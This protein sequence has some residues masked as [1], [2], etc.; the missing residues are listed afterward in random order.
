MKRKTFPITFY[1]YNDVT[2]QTRLVKPRRPSNMYYD[3]CGFLWN[4]SGTRPGLE[5]SDSQTSVGLTMRREVWTSTRIA[6]LGPVQ[7]LGGTSG[8]LRGR[9]G[10]T[11][12]GW[13]CGGSETEEVEVGVERV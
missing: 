8:V 9:Q 2:P 5:T 13:G 11:R 12:R 7:V 3:E 4:W 1:E 10:P 6:N